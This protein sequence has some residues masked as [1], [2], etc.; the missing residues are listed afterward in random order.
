MGLER[1]EHEYRP[2]VPSEE[3]ETTRL[4]SSVGTIFDSAARAVVDT[5]RA[6]NAFEEVRQ[7]IVYAEPSLGLRIPERAPISGNCWA[8]ESVEYAEAL[9]ISL[10]RACYLGDD[11]SVNTHNSDRVGFYA[12][13][14]IKIAQFENAVGVLPTLAQLQKHRSV[15]ILPRLLFVQTAQERVIPHIAQSS[16]FI[17]DRGARNC[18]EFLKIVR[19]S[20][21]Y[22]ATAQSNPLLIDSLEGALRVIEA[23]DLRLETRRRLMRPV[24]EGARMSIKHRRSKGGHPW[25]HRSRG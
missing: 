19:A 23:G 6:W 16:P 8:R 12:A 4:L 20:A 21:S 18:H 9:Q 11:A 3:T 17:L 2:E 25:F 5:G 24:E 15:G 7:E 22:R 13:V 1:I 10:R 14:L